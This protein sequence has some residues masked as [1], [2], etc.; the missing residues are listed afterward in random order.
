LKAP[1]LRTGE[2]AESAAA[3]F[4]VRRGYRL[5]EKNFRS[6]YGEID[7]VMLDRQCLVFVEVRYR[8]NDAYG[9]ALQSVSAAK[10][11]KLRRTAESY[12]QRAGLP[13]FEECRFDV[14]AV[15]GSSPDYNFDL[16]T[17][18]LW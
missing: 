2:N 13:E 1:H 9:G 7:L 14:V 6:R 12:L 17:S 3:R 10:Q 5:V 18:A 16:V 11:A 4:L 15:S 8:R